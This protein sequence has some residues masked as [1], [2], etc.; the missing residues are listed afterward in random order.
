MVGSNSFS[1]EKKKKKDKA[2]IRG[3]ARN[4]GIIIQF[5]VRCPSD[6]TPARQTHSVDSWPFIGYSVDKP[7]LC[8]IYP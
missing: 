3:P 2:H 6:R 4:L 1:R 7:M 5:V 8:F